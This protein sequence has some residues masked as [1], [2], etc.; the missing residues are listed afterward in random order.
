MTVLVTYASKYG[1]TRGIAER[2]GETLTASGVDAVVEPISG[3]AD[4]S[5]YDAFVVGSAVYMGVWLKEATKF[6]RQHSA[7]LASRPL[8]LF[9]SGPL[10]TAMVDGEGKDVR[11]TAAA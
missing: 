8:W 10:G 5:G 2:I 4:L 11:E 7:E 9:S 3:V 1:G 6:A